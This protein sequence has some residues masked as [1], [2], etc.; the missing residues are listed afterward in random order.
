MGSVFISYSW[1]DKAIAQKITDDLRARGIRVW[2]DTSELLPGDSLIQKISKGISDSEFIVMIL[3]R[4]SQ[5]SQWAQRELEIAFRQEREGSSVRFIPI[6]IDDSLIPSFLSD[7]V[8]IDF[9][10]DYEAAIELLA[11]TVAE[12]LPESIPK[13]SEIID[14]EE[15]AEKIE[16]EQ[17]DAR[18]R[19]MPLP[20]YPLLITPTSVAPGS[21]PHSMRLMRPN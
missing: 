14:A 10:N 15:L 18:A 20:I 12:K 1:K 2:I 17:E 19:T 7:R 8:Y 9:Q 6:R 13:V 16:G 4:N 3:S 5:K 11:R 21:D